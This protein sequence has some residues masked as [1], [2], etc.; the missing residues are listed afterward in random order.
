MSVCVS[1]GV[2]QS[3]GDTTS[4]RHVVTQVTSRDNMAELV[5]SRTGCNVE[6]LNTRML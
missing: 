4:Q 3:D 1:A 2:T 5:V 6:L